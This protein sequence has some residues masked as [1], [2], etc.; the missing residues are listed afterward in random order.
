MSKK[1]VNPAVLRDYLEALDDP[2]IDRTKKHALIDILVI[3]ICAAIC[4][5]KTWVDIEDFGKSKKEWF[6][7]FLDLNHGIPSHDTFRRLFI[8]LDPEKFLEVFMSW[9]KA[10]TEGTDLEQLCIDGKA[11]RRSHKK[12]KAL[13][14]LHMVNAWST[15]AGLAL[16]Q[17]KSEGKSNEIKT[18]PK[19]LD[20]L[21]VKGS[22]VSTDAMSCQ[23]NT[24]KKII[25]KEGDYL[26]ALKGNQ[27]NLEKRVKEKFESRK[28]PGPKT[29]NIDSYVSDDEGHGRI[30]KRHCTVIT[31][32]EGKNLGINP[33][34]KW[35]ELNSLIEI[36]SK[37]LDKKSGKESEETRYYISSCKEG[38]QKLLQSVR[39]HWQ[40]ENN[41]HWTLDVTFRE[42]ESRA[43][44]G[45]SAENF[46]MLRQFALNLV[47]K[48][49]S[50]K[51]IR[52]K[53]NIAGWDESFLLKILIGSGKL[54]A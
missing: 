32:K 39:G 20:L 28:K 1:D 19:L 21:D 41:L 7:S 54:D 24:A 4:G 29:F 5:A 44:A 27:E 25:E 42:D 26:F 6:S 52:R 33:L 34:K 22:I 36:K 35:P 8:L 51:A 40:V 30:E 2:R 49:S 9:V 48:E 53:Q 46:S 38:A 16:G 17:L 23:V 10:I 14:A 45:Y 18:V 13:S 50:K 43:R 37:R 47:K 3:A 15:G 11:L 12:G 31:A